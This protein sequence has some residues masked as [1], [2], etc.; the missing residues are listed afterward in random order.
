MPNKQIQRTLKAPMI[1]ALGQDSGSEKM[2]ENRDL[3]NDYA[4]RSLRYTADEDYIA[5]RIS[6]KAGLIEPFLWSGL[7]SIEKYLKALLL[8]KKTSEGF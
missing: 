4:Q 7:H 2:M 3:I 1:W 5:A 8:F 6:Y